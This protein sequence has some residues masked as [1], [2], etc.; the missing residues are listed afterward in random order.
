MSYILEHTTVRVDLWVILALIL[1]IAVTIFFF[2][3]VHNIK[4]TERELEDEL[5]K[6]QGSAV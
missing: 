1:L 5:D 2:I 3:R 6:K 4:K